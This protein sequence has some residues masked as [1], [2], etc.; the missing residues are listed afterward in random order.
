L[1]SIY[2]KI[3]SHFLR[4]NTDFPLPSIATDDGINVSNSGPDPTN[5]GPQ[6]VTVHFGC[7]VTCLTEFITT[8]HRSLKFHYLRVE[9]E[10]VGTKQANILRERGSHSY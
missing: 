3:L 1:K 2:S 7:S 6:C 9:G 4:I 10:V 8:S 5:R